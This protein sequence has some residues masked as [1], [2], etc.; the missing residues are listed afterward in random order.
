M[1]KIHSFSVPDRETIVSDIS[2]IIGRTPLSEVVVDSLKLYKNKLLANGD[3]WC[4]KIPDWKIWKQECLNMGEK[5]LDEA[6]S[7][8]E[9]LT[10][11]AKRTKVYN[12][13]VLR[14][15]IDY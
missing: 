6:I 8:L 2:K 12:S 11:I 15:G 4:N 3:S 5:D 1:A 7:R 10:R 9:Q 13:G 14:S